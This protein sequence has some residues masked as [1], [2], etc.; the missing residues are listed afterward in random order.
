[1]VEK[2][3]NKGRKKEKIRK[4]EETNEDGQKSKLGWDAAE[5]TCGTMEGSTHIERVAR[6]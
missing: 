3:K 5:Q 6:W 2:W 1:M 4:S